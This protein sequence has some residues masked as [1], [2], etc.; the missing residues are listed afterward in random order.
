MISKQI[1]RCT[2]SILFLLSWYNPIFGLNKSI[3][4]NGGN[5]YITLT[6]SGPG[7]T[8][9]F[10]IDSFTIE[11][12]I[13]PTSFSGTNS[14]GNTIV[15]NDSVNGFQGFVLRTGVSQKLEFAYGYG[16]GWNT[17][18]TPTVVLSTNRWTHVAVTKSAGWVQLFVNGQLVKDSNF[19]SNTA[20][21]PGSLPVRIGE[22]GSLN[23]RKFLGNLDEVKIWKTARTLSEIK[24]DMAE[25]CAPYT[26]HLLSYHK[27]DD[28]SSVNPSLIVNS[29]NSI[30]NGI[31]ND[32]IL[33]EAG[34]F[35]I[36]GHGQ[37]YV[38]SSNNY[39][40]C[41]TES[42]TSW[43]TAFTDLNT[44]IRLAFT[45]PFIEKIFIAQGTYKPSQYH[46]SM[47]ADRT[48][49]P[50]NIPNAKNK[51]FHFRT[52][53]EVQGG[54][55]SGGGTQNPYL[56]PT[57]LTGSGVGSLPTDSAYHV[58]YL[59]SSVNWARVNDTTVL[60]GLVIKGAKCDLNSVITGSASIVYG[61]GLFIKSGTNRIHRCVILENQ[62]VNGCAGVFANTGTV[63]IEHSVIKNNQAG[64]GLYLD[65]GFGAYGKTLL[66][67]DTIE[68]NQEGGAHIKSG[69][70]I[71]NCLF[72]NNILNYSD[73]AGLYVEGSLHRIENNTFSMNQVGTPPNSGTGAGIFF[74]QSTLDTVLGNT[75]V[76]NMAG[77]AGGGVYVFGGFDHYFQDNLFINDTSHFG[78]GMYTVNTNTTL[79]SN[80]FEHNYAWSNGGGLAANG[81]DHKI[82]GNLFFQ[83]HALISGGGVQMDNGID[84]LIG[85]C[86]L[87]NSSG[88]YGGGMTLYAAYAGVYN[89]LI[90][91]NASGIS[92]GMD[93]NTISS[94]I[95]GNTFF[96]NSADS[97][98]F[99]NY[100]R[101][102][103]LFIN[104][105]N[106]QINNNIFYNNQ[107]NSV[108]SISGSDFFRMIPTGTNNFKHNL[109]QLS[110]T[111][112]TTIGSGNY[113]LG[114]GALNNI[115]TVNPLFL[116]AQNILG[117]DN[118]LG[119]ADDGLQLSMSSPVVDQGDS[120]LKPIS[121]HI[122]ING[123]ARVSG[124]NMDMGAYEQSCLP[125]NITA[126]AALSICSGN[127]TTLQVNAPALPAA[128]YWYADSSSTVIL[129]TGF[130]FTT[131]VL[132]IT[133]TFWVANVNCINSARTPIVVSV[134]NS[135]PILTNTTNAANQVICP[136][137]ST[138]LTVFS[139]VPPGNVLWYA[140]SS[141]VTSLAT[142]FQFN[143]S[144]LFMTDT[145]WVSALGCVTTPRLP[146]AVTVYP[147]TSTGSSHTACGFYYWPAS[148]LQYTT[149]G[150]YYDTV[151]NSYGCLQ[152]DTLVLT[153]LP[154]GNSSQSVTACVQ[155]VWPVN[156]QLYTTSGI[157]VD[158][159]TGINGCD[160][161]VSLNL[162]L[163]NPVAAIIQ[164]ANQLIASPP[165][166]Q[167]QWLTCNPFQVISNA[168]SQLYNVT[169]NGNYAVVVNQGG[170]ID[171][172]ACATIIGVNTSATTAIP[173]LALIPN[174][175]LGICYL[176]FGSQ[177]EEIQVGVKNV[178][179]QEIL[180]HSYNKESKIELNLSSYPNGI[181][182]IEIHF[183]LGKQVLRLVKGD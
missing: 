111:N 10:T 18:T 42:G 166:A 73:G 158:T 160:S 85:N 19:T 60:S 77:Y 72:Q 134:N 9:H 25:T 162:T 103:A 106:N 75:F 29:A 142:G 152:I 17:L 65:I 171:T 26:N 82:L 169:T 177:Q 153:I 33:S 67:F 165:N 4:V 137:T 110:S 112:Y 62:G 3:R 164:N 87:E 31:M 109:L 58:V 102:G 22:N 36:N 43:L 157:Y 130:T 80:R 179:G 68:N 6:N 113:D 105:G 51:V 132:F 13:R 69:T 1:T 135:A 28:Q 24:D 170:C 167:Y 39:T 46:Y 127:F 5:G 14:L 172:S 30:Y 71:K 32:V 124:L 174:P 154:L 143:T 63:S 108:T 64:R 133:D 16:T 93:V 129:D 92:G 149:S 146:I 84:T 175:T 176:D 79:V 38:D 11:A 115:F 144:T 173:E 125:V 136:G 23:N 15:G 61:G 12:W 49:I 74:A 89:N 139:S 114:T 50:F 101:G 117:T 95:T 120:T 97:T 122:D 70:W 57:V 48:G 66:Q 123:N 99:P 116:N 21:T 96:G 163:F 138:L 34:A 7:S 94:S 52:G 55:P 41:G 119:T 91:R 81:G 59:D 145:F 150:Q 45:Y 27:L 161:L 53:L 90:A 140:D 56:Y 156:N 8:L 147:N 181:Y 180:K 128:I 148:G 78:A 107:I 35:L 98:V 126:S 183:V 168:T 151:V 2:F 54:Y 47:Q 178:M 44:A 20:I 88:E 86:I 141:S 40:G 121:L 182:W 104:Y 118:L 159:L 155:Y 100:Y 76:G 83:N 131:P 37:L